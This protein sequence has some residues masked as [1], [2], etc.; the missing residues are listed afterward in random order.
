LEYGLND[1]Y[2]GI[3]YDGILDD[4]ADSDEHEIED[5]TSALSM[6]GTGILAAGCFFGIPSCLGIPFF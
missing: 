1:D 3:N 4:Y 6:L 2:D 5:N